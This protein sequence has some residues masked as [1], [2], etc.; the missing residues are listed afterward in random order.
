MVR[1]ITATKCEGR[2]SAVPINRGDARV[3]HLCD[4]LRGERVL[5][6]RDTL[7][8]KNLPANASEAHCR[9]LPA[10]QLAQQIA[11]EGDPPTAHLIQAIMQ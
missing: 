3:A 4:T 2:Y 5:G 9:P 8:A 10:L 1:I 6:E 11:L 7:E